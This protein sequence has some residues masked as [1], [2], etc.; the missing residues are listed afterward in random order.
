MNP[1]ANM[2]N[3]YNNG[4]SGGINWNSQYNGM[5]PMVGMMNQAAT[6]NGNNGSFPPAYMMGR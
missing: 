2:N 3:Q 1:M 4:Y 5:G 6:T